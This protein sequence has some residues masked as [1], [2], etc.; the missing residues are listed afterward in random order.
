GT[1][2][3][4]TW[5]LS[6]GGAGSTSYSRSITIDPNKVSTADQSDFPILI[7]ETQAY[8]KDVSHGGKVQNANGC[9]I[10]FTSDSAGTV[11]LDHEMETYD[12]ANGVVAAWIR[13][14][15]LSHVV[16]TPTVIYMWY[17]DPAITAS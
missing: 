5:S 11:K 16:G 17:G 9:D 4:V 13:I 8:L 14:P 3:P 6:G 10:K 7:S 15:T 12:G 1:S 2:T